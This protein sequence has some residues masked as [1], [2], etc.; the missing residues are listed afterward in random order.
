MKNSGIVWND[1]TLDRFLTKPLKMVPGSS[2]T[3]DG[4]S[5]PKERADCVVSLLFHRYW[6]APADQ[7][8]V[9]QLLFMKN[10]AVVGGMLVLAALGPGPASLG[11]R[12]SP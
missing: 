5:D 8:L 9:T 3:Y 6:S 1:K 10:I 2:M 12:R 7:Q 4:V 11:A